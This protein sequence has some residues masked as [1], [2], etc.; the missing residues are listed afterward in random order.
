MKR[1]FSIVLAL[2]LICSCVAIS[3]VSVSADSENL[4]GDISKWAIGQ[5]SSETGFVSSS[6]D[7]DK[8]RI[9]YSDMISVKP[10]EKY[11]FKIELASKLL[12]DD[13]SAISK[14]YHFKFSVR[15]YNESGEI[16][17]NLADIHG[18]VGYAYNEK[19]NSK[20]V[21]IPDGIY[22][23]GVGLYKATNESSF[24]SGQTIIDY[25]NSGAIT[26]SIVKVVEQTTTP[27][28]TM[29]DGAAMR[30]DGKTDGI[31]FSATVDKTAFDEQVAGGTVT[32]IGTLIAKDG[33][34]ISN[35]IVENAVDS[36]DGAKKLTDNQIPVA[37]YADGTTMQS[38]NDAN[39]YVIVGSLVAIN[40]KNATQKYVA[41]AYVKYVDKTGGEHVMYASALSTPR[42]IAEVANNI[43]T[44]GDGYY[45]SLCKNHKDVVHK[46]AAYIK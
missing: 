1:I 7:T 28:I 25:I 9:Y 3:A 11:N 43:V 27:T 46:W 15:Q 26:V 34:D 20:E 2:A 10:G 44:A 8:K 18:K 39:K 31:R 4:I 14:D 40:E 32:E 5:Y 42:S 33:T 23:L 36:S 21:T 35:V 19:V 38:D 13:G 24:S 6:T 29:L 30:I 12:K 16:Q 17:G 37:K 45:S 22:T 41:R